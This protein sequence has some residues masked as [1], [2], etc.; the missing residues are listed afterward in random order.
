MCPHELLLNPH[1]PQPCPPSFLQQLALL[2]LEVLPRNLA[3]RRDRFEAFSMDIFSQ[4]RT[5]LWLRK[6]T[7]RLSF[8]PQNEPRVEATS[9]VLKKAFDGVQNDCS[10]L[11]AGPS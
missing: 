6:S 4:H 9:S 11:T 7:F 10:R 1:V 5:E 2:R 3:G 8:A